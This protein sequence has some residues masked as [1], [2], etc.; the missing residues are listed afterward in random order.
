MAGQVPGS[1]SSSSA[2]SGRP[3]P[4]S[5]D[6]GTTADAMAAMTEQIIHEALEKLRREH[7]ARLWESLPDEMSERLPQVCRQAVEAQLWG[8]VRVALARTP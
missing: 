4:L 7:V 6:A 2:A 3:T 1:S 5:G 8:R